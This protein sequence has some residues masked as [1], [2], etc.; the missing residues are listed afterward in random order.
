MNAIERQSS[1]RSVDGD[2][3]VRAGTTAIRE[4]LLQRFEPAEL[5]Q[6][7]VFF[8]D[9]WELRWLSNAGVLE[10]LGFGESSRNI[11]DER[12]ALE[13]PTELTSFLE[14]LDAMLRGQAG[15]PPSAPDV[16]TLA[17]EVRGAL[18]RR[19]ASIVLPSSKPTEAAFVLRLGLEVGVAFVL[20]PDPSTFAWTV[21]TARPT[22]IAAGEDLLSELVSDLRGRS[23]WRRRRTLS[24]TRFLF[25]LDAD[26]GSDAALAVFRGFLAAGAVSHRVA[27]V[28]E[29]APRA[30]G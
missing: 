24:A 20:P 10:R 26:S 13:E 9:G 27:L 19:R 22:I 4:D 7:F 21:C 12:G 28:D 3:S 6:P 1:V 11:V 8:R 30:A 16:G 5:D 2:A 29:H 18:R 14:D 25:G 23:A 15:V 17:R